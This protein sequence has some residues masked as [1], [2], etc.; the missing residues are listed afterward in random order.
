MRARQA[1]PGR[2]LL[3]GRNFENAKMLRA[4]YRRLL[5]FHGP[6]GW[7]PIVNIR[8]GTGEY[9]V[10]APRSADDFF[11]IAV[12]AILT[13]NVSWKNVDSALAVLKK[14]NL[15]SPEKLMRMTPARLARLITSTGYYNQKA[16]K[17]KNFIRWYATRRFD[18]LVLGEMEP[19]TV[20]DELL[21]VNG[22]G[23]ETADSILLYSLGAKIF[24]VD[25]YTMRMFSRLGVL[26][27]AEKY[28]VV[29]DLFH[30]SFRG[31]AVEYNEYH[32]LI[33]AHGK[34]YCR[35]KPVCDACCLATICS[36]HETRVRED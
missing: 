1:A 8:L 33:V 9:H 30:R 25:A 21:S 32:A 35:K 15:L 27:G 36:W 3:S 23:P 2:D 31:S 4:V 11:E 14:K 13:Q 26:T 7:W 5:A 12:G 6:Q 20:R 18:W 10:G 29:Q 16:K 34:D 17:I 24:V 19:L 22:I 28:H